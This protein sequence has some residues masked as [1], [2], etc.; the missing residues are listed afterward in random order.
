MTQKLDLKETGA[1]I[2]DKRNKD[3]LLA[4]A[5][6]PIAGTSDTLHRYEFIQAYLRQ[7]KEFGAQRQA[8]EST[9][10]R[11]ALA[12]LAR[13][14]GYQDVNRLMWQMETE[15]LNA[16]AHLFKEQNVEDVSLH[17]AIDFSG[18]AGI[19]VSKDGK[20]LK[21][22][23][24][25]LKNN[26]TVQQL[27]AI[28]KDLK[29]QRVRAKVSLENA[30]VSEDYFTVLELSKLE[31]NPVIAPLIQNLIFLSGSSNAK[32]GYWRNGALVSFDGTAAALDGEEQIR[33]AH[34]HDLF[35]AGVWTQYQG[36]LFDRQIVQPFKQVFRELYRPNEDE[37]KQLTHSGRYAGHQV[38]PKKTLAL[39]KSRGWTANYEEGLQKAC[40]KENI[41]I[42]LYAIADW[43][44]PADIEAPA[45]ETVYFHDRKTYKALPMDQISPILFSEAMRDID[46]VVSVAHAGGV[47]P[48]ASLST[49]EMRESLLN[50]MI[51]LMRIDNVELRKTHA[52][53]KGRLGEYTVHL[54]S[55]TVQ[56]MATGSIF[57]VPVHSQH[58]GRLFLP[59]M[60]DDPKTAEI[61]SKILLL[62]E[63][64]KIKDPE[65][66]RQIWQ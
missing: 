54:G 13:N 46:L 26:E 44:S 52:F 35:Q 62:A 8:S 11:I 18:M 37:L 42:S 7:A 25:R 60:D 5:L 55:G 50:E 49:I 47:D 41:I 14:A 38:Q 31:Q 19:A 53:I 17:L 10:G 40:Y 34:P 56:K 48:E 51:R 6:I 1:I 45:I 43:F 36:D 63:D 30:M 12:N 23:P 2:K 3:Q 22:I 59:F 24:S 39:L 65:I 64:A 66:L 29:L 58:R 4:Y 61:I 27:K 16:S 20:S 28:Q 57:I 9:A 15:K 33:L 21:D 32:H